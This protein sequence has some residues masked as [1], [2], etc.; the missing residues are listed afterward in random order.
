MDLLNRK[1]LLFHFF[2]V[3]FTIFLGS[4][5]HFIY[6]LSGFF[7]PVA[8]IGAVNESTWEHLKIGFWPAFLFSVI[9]YFFYGKR[10]KSFCFAKLTN[11]YTIPIVIIILFYGYTFFINHSLFLDI[12]IFVLSIIVAY[13]LSYKILIS[14]KDFSQY[15]ILAIIFI[16]LELIAFSLFSYFPFENFLFLDPITGLYGIIK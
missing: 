14:K 5:L 13:F 4:F 3:I 2:G 7:R 9:E 12:F 6:E 11:L 8:L 16:I 10:N 1:I 15:R